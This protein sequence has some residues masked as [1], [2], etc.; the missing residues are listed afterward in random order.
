MRLKGD[1]FI[2]FLVGIK[3][4]TVIERKF[5]IHN[6]STYLYI[7]LKIPLLEPIMMIYLQK[8]ENE[9]V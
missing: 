9:Y 2:H 8:Q 3:S 7:D 4:D 1:I 5:C 6:K